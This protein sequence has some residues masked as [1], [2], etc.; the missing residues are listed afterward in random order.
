M[1]IFVQDRLDVPRLRV[2]A[3]V[4]MAIGVHGDLTAAMFAEM[5]SL[6]G[7]AD[8]EACRLESSGTPGVDGKTA[9]RHGRGG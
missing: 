4:P 8:F 7:A 6:C 2:I 5:Q 1:Y 3:K 9:W